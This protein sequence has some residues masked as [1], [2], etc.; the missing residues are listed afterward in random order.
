M[1]DKLIDIIGF[2][3]MIFAVINITIYRVLPSHYEDDYST[4]LSISNTYMAV[5][6]LYFYINYKLKKKKKS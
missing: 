3:A 2:I 5:V 1:K 6:V 4:Y